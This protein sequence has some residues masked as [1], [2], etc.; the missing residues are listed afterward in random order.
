EQ[1]AIS[2]AEIHTHTLASDGMVSAVELVRAA[3]AKGLAV[4]CVT[5]DDTLAQL[6]EA[7]DEGARLGVDVVRGEEVTAAFPP[8]VHLLALFIERPI[9]MH[10]SVLDTV[11][12][13][14]DQGGLVVVAHPFM[15]TWFASM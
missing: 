10:M 13:I 9:R 15:P 7:I 2:T 6:D 4:V 11:G 8:G 5:D 1:P 14:R 12:A 3:T